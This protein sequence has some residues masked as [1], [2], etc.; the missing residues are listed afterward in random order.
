MPLQ[1]IRL[2]LLVSRALLVVAVL[3]SLCVSSNVGPRFL[4][5]PAISIHLATNEP[6]HQD[7]TA[8]SH[9]VPAE[10]DSF[11]VPMMAQ[12]QKRPD[13]VPQQ[14][15]LLAFTPTSGLVLPSLVRVSNESGYPSSLLARLMFSQRFGRA[16]P[17]S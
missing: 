10:S 16:P 2:K 6:E 9:P 17:A 11:R 8:L 12:A 3:I 14:P 4:P 7:E 15:Q 13:R 5:M 1:P